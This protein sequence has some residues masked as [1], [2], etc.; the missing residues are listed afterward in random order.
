MAEHASPLPPPPRRRMHRREGTGSPRFLTFSCYRRVQ[1]FHPSIADLFADTL[2]AARMKHRLLSGTVTQKVR[3]LLP[4]A[5]RASAART[6]FLAA[7]GDLTQST[8]VDWQAWVGAKSP[9]EVPFATLREHA[10]RC[11]QDVDGLQLL[12]DD[13][14]LLQ[15]V[16]AER[17]G[18]LIELLE[19]H[20]ALLTGLDAACRRVVYQ[21]LSRAAIARSPALATFTGE[22]HESRRAQFRELDRKLIRLRQAKIALDLARRPVEPGINAGPKSEWTGLALVQNEAGKQ[23]RHIPMRHLLSRAG[24]AVQ[25]LTPCFMMSPLS[26]AQCLKPGV[27]NFDLIIMDE[28]SQLRPEDAIGAI[29]R[30]SQIVVVGDPRCRP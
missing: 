20:R 15:D 16:Y 18:P 4:L 27:L 1:L 12:I 25:S 24:T 22:R 17:L 29:A 8:A 13:V 7:I 9:A 19:R 21:S 2:A 3:L 11:S 6:K 10:A 30:G 26:V 28:A 5:E 23:K 14:R